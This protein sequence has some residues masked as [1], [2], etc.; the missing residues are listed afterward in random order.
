ME[1]KRLLLVINPVSGRVKLASALFE[2]TKAFCDAGYKISLRMTQAHGDG[3]LIVQNEAAEHDLIVACGGDGTLN[4]CITGLIR[5]AADI[6]IGY[7]PCGTTNDFAAGLGIERDNYVQAAHN[8]INGSPFAIDIGSFGLNR[9]FTYIASF[10]AFTETS[11]NAPQSRKNALGHLAYILEGMRDL[12]NIKP[13]HARVTINDDMVLEGDYI[14]GCVSNTTSIGGVVRIDSSRVDFSD[15]AFEV[16]LVKNPV[17]ALEISRIMLAIQTGM[18]EDGGISFHH[19]HK[20]S[21]ETPDSAPWALD[22]EFAK[23][24]E[25]VDISVMEKVIRIVI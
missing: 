5:S 15:G 12:W 2:I 17:T 3:T 16:M 18:Y 8:I 23:G 13:V 25:R 22:G 10:G 9:Y 19:A 6:P 11:Y 7:I 4:E 14:F 21:F 20:V 24:A 1:Q